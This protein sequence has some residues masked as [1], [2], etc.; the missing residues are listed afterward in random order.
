MNQYLQRGVPFIRDTS[1]HLEIIRTC[2]WREE[3]SSTRSSS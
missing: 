2:N 3:L 1:A